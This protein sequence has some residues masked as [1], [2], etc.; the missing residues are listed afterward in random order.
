[1]INIDRHIQQ[2][3]LVND[4]VIVPGLGGFVAHKVDAKYDSEHN[5]FYPPKRTIGFNPIL[6][7]NDSL[8]IQSL[9]ET[10]D[11]SYPEAMNKIEEVVDNIIKN[12][13]EGRE[14]K[15][16]AIGKL[17]K[18]S[19]GKIKFI[20]YEMGIASPNFYGLSSL[21]L[22]L[23]ENI[24]QFNNTLSINNKF[25]G[26]IIAIDNSDKNDKRLSISLKAVKDVC[27]AASILAAIFIG[28]FN[29]TTNNSN[30]NKQ[31]LKSE[32][33]SPLLE[34]NK[35]FAKKNIPIEHKDFKS[36]WTLVLASHVT[37]D[38]AIIFIN[39]LKRQGFTNTRLHVSTGSNK[40]IFGQFHSQNDAI[41]ALNNLKTYNEFQQA[42][43]LKIDN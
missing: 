12:I 19:N 26:K 32:I 38:N 17:R 41:K 23:K 33:F 20:P 36:F 40:V 5:V 11:I 22:S 7:M 8:L 28:G 9:I 15:I 37:K 35:F 14:F 13:D 18:E 16:E 39:E 24:Y 29:T 42:W 6:K 25:K 10:Y 21:N 43:I 27:V 1:M 3:L 34:S 2:L 4:C 30:T 31:E